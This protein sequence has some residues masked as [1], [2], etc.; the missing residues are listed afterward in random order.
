MPEEAVRKK[1]PPKRRLIPYDNLE[2]IRKR[3][4]LSEG[5]FSE[6]MGYDPSTIYGWRRSGQAPMSAGLAAETLVRRQ[7]RDATCFVLL[8]V[9]HGTLRVLA[10]VDKLDEALLADAEYYLFR[11]EPRK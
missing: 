3:L 6:A 7:A 5:D 8:E 10:S 2:S 9:S 1:A 4:D 11:K